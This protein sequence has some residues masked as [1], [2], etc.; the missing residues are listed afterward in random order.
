MAINPN[1]LAV[2][3]L[4]ACDYSYNEAP[5]EGDPLSTYKDSGTS[6]EYLP[7]DHLFTRVGLNAGTGPVE[8]QFQLKAIPT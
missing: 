2:L 4:I 8:G 3:N 1:Q 5:Q 7:P 6:N